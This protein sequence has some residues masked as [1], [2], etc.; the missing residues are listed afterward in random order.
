MTLDRNPKFK[1]RFGV[2]ISCLRSLGVP[3]QLLLSLSGSVAADFVPEM[4]GFSVSNGQ[5]VILLNPLTM[6]NREEMAQGMRSAVI[7]ELR[8]ED[9]AIPAFTVP[10]VDK[11]CI[12]SAQG[13]MLAR[14][15]TFTL[16]MTALSVSSQCSKL[17][18][19]LF[20]PFYV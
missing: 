9:V 14:P 1:G 2:V 10:E 18:S 3:R 4:T 11:V 19:S 7:E 8:Q 17:C 15:S 6:I 20:C 12:I 5:K 16:Y 13:L